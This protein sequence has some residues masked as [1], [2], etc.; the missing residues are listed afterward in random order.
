MG[1]DELL[2]LFPGRAL[3][4]LIE[5][6]RLIVAVGGIDCVSALCHARF[7]VLG[8]LDLGMTLRHQHS[9]AHL[10]WNLMETEAGSSQSLCSAKPWGPI[11]VRPVAGCGVASPVGGRATGP[12]PMH[13]SVPPELCPVQC[14]FDNLEI[15]L[16]SWS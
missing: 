15:D 8:S 14:A 1:E 6:T 16:I 7:Q 10:T 4:S 3:H 2:H 9:C 5:R 12:S 13:T 11:R